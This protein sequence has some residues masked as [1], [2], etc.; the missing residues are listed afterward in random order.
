MNKYNYSYLT[1][2]ATKYECTILDSQEKINQLPE[3]IEINAKCGHRTIVQ[4]KHFVIR[5]KVY[6]D[7]CMNKITQQKFVTICSNQKCKKIFSPSSCSLVYCSV[8]CRNSSR[9]QTKETKMKIKNKLKTIRNTTKLPYNH[10]SLIHKCGN[11]YIRE[12]LKDTFD[13]DI[14]NRC[15]KY[16]HIYKPC[17]I[18][19]DKWI[20]IEIKYSTDKKDIYYSF[21]FHKTYKNIVILLINLDDKNMWLFPPNTLLP[22]IKLKINISTKY[23]EYLT[24]ELQLKEQLKCYYH[25]YN[26]ICINKEESQKPDTEYENKNI[27]TL[28]EYKYAIFRLNTIKFLPFINPPSNFELFNFLIN[29]FKIQETVCYNNVRNQLLISIY[30]VINSRYYPYDYN[31][32][33]F[34]WI[35]ERDVKLFYVIPQNVMAENNVISHGDVKGKLVLNINTNFPWI[36]KHQFNYETINE[37][38]E[39]MKLMKL[40]NLE[41]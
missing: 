31:D 40:F 34:Y 24:D 16:N 1:N 7:D 39:K 8:F 5:K 11:K 32:N 33:D 6:C 20:P 18:S 12:L 27:H 37:P 15:C 13:I 19:D 17:D 14:C 25:E 21:N 10:S 9:N 22:S 26:N 23:T 30:K 29:G 35:N 2:F 28:I 38:N 3:T 36:I 4:I 41:Q